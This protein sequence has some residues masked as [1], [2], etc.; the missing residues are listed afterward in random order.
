MGGAESILSLVTR[1]ITIFDVVDKQPS[2]I[3]GLRAK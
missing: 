2:Q 3:E 1:A